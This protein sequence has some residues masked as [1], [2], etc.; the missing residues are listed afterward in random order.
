[1]LPVAQSEVLPD[2][3][4]SVQDR[5]AAVVERGVSVVRD[6][7]IPELWREYAGTLDQKKAAQGCGPPCRRVGR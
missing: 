6:F 4:R 7:G 2:V 3:G 5:C 1:M